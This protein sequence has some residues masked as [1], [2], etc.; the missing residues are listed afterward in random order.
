M[1]T[2]KNSLEELYPACKSEWEIH[3]AWLPQGLYLL[4]RG[5]KEA[6]PGGVIPYRTEMGIGEARV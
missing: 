3:E 1:I 4:R 2:R 5:W 6:K